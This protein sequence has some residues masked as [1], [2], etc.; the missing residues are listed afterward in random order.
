MFEMLGL[1]KGIEH[2]CARRFD[3]AVRCETRLAGLRD[4]FKLF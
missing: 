3:C 1:G 4:D 2:E